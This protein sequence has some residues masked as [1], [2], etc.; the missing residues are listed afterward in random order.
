MRHGHPE[1]FRARTGFLRRQFLQDGDL[2]FTN[3][4]TEEIVADAL[5]TVGGWLDRIFSPLVTLWVFLGQVLSA[6][7]S[8]RAAVAR[9]IA[10]RLARGQRPC[11]ARTGAYCQARQRLPEA[12]FSEAALR[13]GRALDDGV[14]KRRLWKGRRV[15]VYDGSSVT[16]PD[17]P[18]NQAE[19]P[20]PVAQKPGLGFPLARIAAVFSLACG[21]VVGLGTCRYAGKGQSDLGLL[22]KLLD[23]FRP[24]DIMLADRLMCA[25]TEMVMLK[26]RG[27]DS[28]CR[29]SSHRTADFRRGR[30]LGGGDHVVVWPKPQKPRTIDREA[31]AALPESLTVREC[32]VRVGR[33]GFRTRVLVVATTLLDATEYAKDD[34]AQLYRARWNAELDLRSLKQ[35]LQMDV[36]RCKT[37]ESVRK[38]LWAHVLAYNL[39]R[40][41]MAQAADRHGL[42]PRSVSF[43]GALQTLEAFQPVIALRGERDA[44]FRRNLYEGLLDA[45]ASHRVGDRP[46]RY[47]PRRRKRRPKPYD[48]LVKPRHEAKQALRKGI[49]EK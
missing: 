14:A 17:T 40:T 6:D 49:P 21:A 41:V 37:P 18:A 47:E 46:D 31:Y 34:L 25:W 36:L 22:R 45:V 7:H 12:F 1:S 19:Y 43:K 15:Y 44:A 42:D 11:S 24:G 9:L 48:R 29:F 30:R 32:R 16:M 23:V 13:T 35:V 39:I 20:Q 38:E 4:L 26:L 5:A 33:P 27:V 3:V 2:P 28:V 10:H 8:C